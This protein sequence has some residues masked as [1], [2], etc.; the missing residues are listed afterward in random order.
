MIFES[1]SKVQRINDCACAKSILRTIRIPGLVE[2]PAQSIV[3]LHIGSSASQFVAAVRG[4]P[5]QRRWWAP[6]C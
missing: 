4:S 6:S 1:D 5:T 3:D 2:M